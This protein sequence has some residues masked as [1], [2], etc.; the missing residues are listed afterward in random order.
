MKI[1]TYNVNSVRTRLPNLLDWLG[2]AAPDVVCLQE[3][4]CQP[5]QFPE[6]E[7]RAA[8]YES[9][10]VGQKSYNGVAIL[11]KTPITLV[12]GTLGDEQARYI[13]VEIAGVRVVNI[14]APNGNP[15]ASE[16]FPYKLDWLARLE[17]RMRTL[18]AEETP[19]VVCGDYNIIPEEIDAHDPAAWG[20]DALFQPQAR[21]MY[22]RFLNL[23]LSDAFRIFEPRGGH[24]TFWDYQA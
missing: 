12:S 24:Y 23:G 7:I 15:V 8:G 16:K 20:G 11:S 14:Y 9:A 5:D 3:L 17:A 4:K 19:F 22:R 1:A 21:A 10:V 18:L 6:M 13:E 2:R